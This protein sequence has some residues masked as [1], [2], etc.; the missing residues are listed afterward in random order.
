[1]SEKEAN[2]I[3]RF[4]VGIAIAVAATGIVQVGYLIHWVGGAKVRIDHNEL[5]I[6]KIMTDCCQ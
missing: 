1:M 6:A 2:G 3:K 5:N 4:M